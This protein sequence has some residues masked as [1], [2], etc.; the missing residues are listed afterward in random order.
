MASKRKAS[1]G[2]QAPK[3]PQSGYGQFLSEQRLDIGETL[4]KEGVD[5]R[6]IMTETAKRAG[7]LWKAL[8][9][10]VQWMANNRTMLTEKVMK[11]QGVEKSKAFFLL[12]NAG[13]P[14]YEA[15]PAAEK[16]KW[17]D[18]ALAGKEKNKGATKGVK[19][20]K[21]GAPKRPLGAY[22]LWLSERRELLYDHVMKKHG[23]HKSKAF[24]M[25]YKEGKPLWDAIPA[26]ERQMHEARAQEAKEKF[27]A[28]VKEWK[29]LSKS[30]GA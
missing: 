13:K 27:Q 30:G 6:K 26:A 17:E 9:G 1:E 20:W 2:P 22:A 5:Q 15:L 25:F 16:K 21:D 19:L 24:L 29:E 3:K 8:A 18:K 14:I 12:Q 10:Y 11:E 28:D 4:K 7:E 23:V